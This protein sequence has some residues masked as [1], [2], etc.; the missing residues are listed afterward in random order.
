[1]KIVEHDKPKLATVKMNCDGAID[2]KLETNGEAVK[3]CFSRP[4]FTIFSG[5]MGAGKTSL[6]IQMLKGCMRKT[7]HNMYVI[8]PEISL[9][10]ISEKD[11]IFSKYL[12]EEH[13]YHEYN[14]ETLNEIYEKVKTNAENDEYSMLI[15][16]DFG[17]QMKGDKKCEQILQK[18]ITKMRHLKLGQTW[19]LC[20]NYYQMPKKLR[21]LATNIVLW[22]TN[23]AQNKKLFEEAFQMKQNQFLELM[24]VTPSSHDW[25]LLNL[26]YKRMFNKD[27][28][29]IIID[30]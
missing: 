1:M 30:E 15:I 27:W 29:E 3:V 10:S 12:D 22:N 6:V 21:E 19:I 2:P 16:D 28:N 7:H 24:K 26:K 18:I 13:L 23:K 5:G 9:H 20:Q 4:N 8:I 11:N 14:E 17:S 25:I